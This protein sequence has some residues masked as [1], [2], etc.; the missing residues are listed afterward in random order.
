VT[1][2]EFDA[3]MKILTDTYGAKH[4]TSMRT[5]GFWSMVKDRSGK[6][7]R[8]TCEHWVM[9]LRS[10]PMAPDVQRAIDEELQTIHYAKN[11]EPPE[12]EKRMTLERGDVRGLMDLLKLRSAGKITHAQFQQHLNDADRALAQSGVCHY[13]L[14]QGLVLGEKEGNRY[15]FKC[16]CEVGSK[17]LENFPIYQPSGE[18]SHKF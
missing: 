3:G 4:F 18:Y 2:F 1:D 9:N 16:L 7:W 14:G 12:Q 17:R 6:W 5:V 8:K 15:A 11:N 10:A 13:C